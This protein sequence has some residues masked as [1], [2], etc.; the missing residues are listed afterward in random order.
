MKAHS[1]NLLYKYIK[2]NQKK[3]Y[4]LETLEKGMVYYGYDAKF[5]EE[6]KKDYKKRQNIMGASTILIIFILFISTFMFIK[7]AITGLVLY[8]K[9]VNHSE[10]I[11]LEFNGSQVYT[12][13]TENQTTLKSV[14]LSGSYNPG[15]YVK[16]Y[17]VHENLK[18]LI[19]DSNL[20]EDKDVL[21]KVTGFVVKQDNEAGTNHPPVWQSEV[22]R[23]DIND[24]VEID[25]DEYFYDKDDDTLSY[26]FD[27][28]SNLEILLNGS[29]LMVNNENDISGNKTLSVYAS[30]DDVTKKKNIVLVLESI[31]EV[32]VTPAVNITNETVVDE[33]MGKEIDIRLEYKTGS[34]YD[35]DDNGIETTTGVIDLSVE[36]SSFNW[37]ADENNLCTLWET[38]SVEE[39]ESV[40][41]CYGGEECCGSAG[42]MPSREDWNEVF[43]SYYGQHGAT[44]NNVIYAQVYHYDATENI[45]IYSSRKANLSA[46]YYLGAVKF[47]DICVE[48][49]ALFGFNSTSYKLVFEINDT[50][51]YLD[52]VDYSVIEEVNVTNNMPLLVKEI[53][54]I[55]I[56]KNENYTIDLSEYFSDAD[57]DTLQYGAYETEN[58]SVVIDGPIATIVPD[59]DFVGKKYMFFKANN[60]L[61]ATVSNVF[62]VSIS[63]KPVGRGETVSKTRVA[64]NRPVKWVKKVKLD[65]PEEKVIVNLTVGAK[66]IT[67]TKVKEGVKEKI[68]DKNVK[69]NEI[70][71]IKEL[72]EY[73]AEKEDENIDVGTLLAEERG[74]LPITGY[75]VR[76]KTSDLPTSPELIISEEVEEVEVEYYTQGPT[77]EEEQLTEYKKRIVISSEIHYEDIL[78]YTFIEKEAPPN[79]IRLYWLVD[80]SRIE[81]S[82]DKYDANEN[83]LVDYIEWNVPSLSN[84][85][86]EVEITVLNVQS[87]PAVGGNWEVKFTIAGTANLTIQPVQGTYFNIDLEFLELRCGNVLLEPLYDGE[88][89]FF[90]NY[91][92]SEEG[93]IVNKVLTSGEHHLE[94]LFG[95]ETAYADNLAGSF[96][97]T[98]NVQGRL[99]NASNSPLNG[100][101]NFT[102]R[103]YESYTGG[104]P[105]FES[106]Q[107]L[108]VNDGVYDSI[109]E[110]SAL[111]F[112]KPYYLG[113]NINNTG[114]MSPRL[115]LTSTPYSYR[116]ITAENLSCD[117]CVGG[118]NLADTIVL[119]ANIDFTGKN[120]SVESSVFY[121]DAENSRVG[122]GTSSPQTELE[123]AGTI[124]A[125]AIQIGQNAVQVESAA[126]KISNVTEYLGGGGNGSILR[127]ETIGAAIDNA[128]INRS[129]DLS[130][131]QSDITGSCTN[132]VVVG[133]NDDGSLNCE[134]DDTGAVSGVGMFI[135]SSDNKHIVTN[136]SISGGIT[137]INMSDYFINGTS[138]WD[139]LDNSTI[140]RS[141]DL[142]DYQLKTENTSL[143]NVTDGNITPSDAGKNVSTPPLF[144]D[145]ENEKVGIGITAPT[146]PLH[147]IG[148]ANISG[149]LDVGSMNISGVTFSQGDLDIDNSLRVAGGANVSGDL[150]VLG[151]IYGEIPDGF[152]IANYSA[153]YAASGFDNE[154]FTSRYDARTD[155]YGK[156]NYSAEYSASGFDNE[157]FTSRYDAR[158]DRYGKANYS[159]EYSASGFDNENYSAEYSASGWKI[160]NVTEYLGDGGNGSVLRNGTVGAAID[161][162]TINRSV[163]LSLYNQSVNLSGYQSDITGNCNGRV[164]VGINDDGS[165]NCEVDDTGSSSGVGMFILSSDNKHIVPNE[166]ISIAINT[167]NMSDYFINGTSIWDILDNGTI[168]RSIDL[169]DYQLKTENTSL[170]NRSGNNIFNGD[171]DGNVGIGTTDPAEKLVVI[172]KVNISDSLNVSGT[173]QATTFRG[174]GSKLTGIS[175]GQ[176]WNSSG[177]TAFLNDT[178]AN[179]GIGATNPAHKLTV[180]GTLNITGNITLD[181]SINIS[182][183]NGQDIFIDAGGGEVYIGDG[184]GKLTV[185]T[186]DPLFSINGESYATY[187]SSMLG[188]KE[189]ITG[190]AKTAKQGD[191][192]THV[193]DFDKEKKG[194]DLWVWR[195]IVDF[196]EGNVEVI[197]TPYGGFARM[198]YYISS[199]KIIFVSDKEVEFSFR[200]TGKRFD[201]KDWPTYVPH[202]GGE[203]LK[204]GDVVI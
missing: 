84:Q 98:I 42:L 30:D 148:D 56:D 134:V 158:T 135:L 61:L 159:A 21:D 126:F 71:V 154:N 173:V 189:E 2:E 193:I 36:G 145:A 139:I 121:V 16:A 197:A 130:G 68:A 153:E 151:N 142:G 62:D 18:Y 188:I 156:A 70:G 5:A 132:Q 180:D 97:K 186:V 35:V 147:V 106:N 14:R 129:V 96:P 155:R 117:D 87:Y 165:L 127:N 162:A 190:R 79:A 199:N 150:T 88:K 160:G 78:A 33:S 65:S 95:D 44:Q 114:E 194:T 80:G 161:N 86:Y 137:T 125:S 105:V 55:T 140:N 8:S 27:D 28:V 12:L 94:F 116:A 45:E 108:E 47:D 103:L 176:I 163:D 83:G 187:L 54:N 118:S 60:S 23:F 107:T 91:N 64:I 143:W 26:S 128:T 131:Y 123:V 111:E 76:E 52:S 169:G 20:L 22:E 49:C 201:Y 69:I 53:S 181:G 73:E 66:N 179:V 89:V 171:F 136:E 67:V 1:K 146:R 81:V 200:L 75:S 46:R 192:F 124:N 164:V 185:G 57:G 101:Y 85:T 166:T 37:E 183:T 32:N 90:E 144:V 168:N 122:I 7:P 25:L 58:L 93:K 115:N 195:Q 48:T 191:V 39:E 167:I 40:I 102:F 3:G 109:L 172:G 63:D 202:K 43:Y 51:L 203:G 11:S 34:V 10:G 182:S 141:I 6:L 99:T 41:V 138:I 50:V 174:D 157:N 178:T 17:L 92:C 133:I 198:Y 31:A 15:G 29:V 184:T 72:A 110:I 204:P 100:N 152:K 13:H 77:S 24:S 149:R 82:T 38:Y 113:I 175:T 74:I 120:F 104:S 112:D 19:F 196:N 177:A 9:E 4:S 170:W 119:D 59:K